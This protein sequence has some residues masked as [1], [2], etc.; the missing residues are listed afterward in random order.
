MTIEGMQRR[1]ATPLAMLLGLAV[2][3]CCDD[4]PARQ[5][6]EDLSG[7]FHLH[8]LAAS[9]S[10]GGEIG[11]DSTCSA[12]ESVTVISP[13]E[14]RRSFPSDTLLMPRARG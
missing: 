14:R 9:T 8:V 2:A 1:L 7:H 10:L 12:G 11:G 3:S 6:D 13:L 5:V 4:E